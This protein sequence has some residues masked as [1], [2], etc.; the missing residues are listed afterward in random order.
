[1]HTDVVVDDDMIM[2]VGIITVRVTMRVDVI[3][4]ASPFNDSSV[5]LLMM[6]LIMH[7]ACV[8]VNVVSTLGDIRMF[9]MMLFVV[10]CVVVVFVVMFI[11]WSTIDA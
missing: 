6:C 3:A 8:S 9:S 2:C 11:D 4:E 1:M 10:G 5:S 7:E